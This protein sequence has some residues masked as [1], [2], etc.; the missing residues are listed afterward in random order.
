MN[1]AC[2]CK[3]TTD[4]SYVDRKLKTPKE[5]RDAE[6]LKRRNII[7]MIKA[8]AA[9]LQGKYL[10]FDD[11]DLDWGFRDAARSVEELFGLSDGATLRYFASIE[12]TAEF[13]MLCEWK[14]TRQ[15]LV[16]WRSNLQGPKLP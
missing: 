1:Q 14:P 16:C 5:L 13:F 15:N 9:R 7:R 4:F 6:R 3:D 12:V 10:G 8:R 2:F 11:I